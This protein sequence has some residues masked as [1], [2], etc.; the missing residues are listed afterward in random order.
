MT[1]VGAYL[2]FDG[3]TV[4]LAQEHPPTGTV[5]L[6]GRAK[7]ELA[8]VLHDKVLHTDAEMNKADWLT[9]TAAIL[10][11]LGIGVGLWWADAVAALAISGSVLMDGWKSLRGAVHDLMDVQVTT[12]DNSE[13]LPLL[14]RIEETVTAA[15]GVGDFSIRVRDMGH[16]FHVELRV[17]P[18]PARDLAVDDIEALCRRVAAL[19]EQI[20]DVLIMPVRRIPH[21]VD[22]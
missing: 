21:R 4:L 6:L 13:P 14:D 3:A 2:V 9:A 18:E 5:V 16:L 15:S 10:G 11:I 22:T 7:L 1:V 20:E 8:P 12:V 19:D 17:V